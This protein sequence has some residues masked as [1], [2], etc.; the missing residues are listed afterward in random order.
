MGGEPESFTCDDGR[1]ELGRTD[2]R[3]EASALTGRFTR[4]GLLVMTFSSG[5]L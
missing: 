1:T 5:S 4:F 2:G 3:M